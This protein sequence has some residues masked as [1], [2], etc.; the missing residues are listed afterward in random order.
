[1]QCNFWELLKGILLQP[2]NNV[3]GWNNIIDNLYQDKQTKVIRME[4]AST[5]HISN[6]Y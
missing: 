4:Q 2:P 1:M 3:S 6:I 5:I